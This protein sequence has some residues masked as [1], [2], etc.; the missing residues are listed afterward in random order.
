MDLFNF[1]FNSRQK[2]IGEN[3]IKFFSGIP[4]GVT[5]STYLFTEKFGGTQ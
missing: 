5:Y 2:L 3:E 1:R 4:K